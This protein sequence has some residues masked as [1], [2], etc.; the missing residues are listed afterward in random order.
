MTYN[1]A[2]FCLEGFFA[3][4]ETQKC[5]QCDR[6]CFSCVG[7]K[8]NCTS[9]NSKKFLYQSKCVEK[10]P[11]GSLTLQGVN[12]IRLVGASS[13]TEGRVEILHDGL[14]GTVCDDSFDILD[15]QVICR[16]LRLGGA[17]EARTRAKYGQ[18]TGKIWIDDLRCDGTEKRIQDCVMHNGNKKYRYR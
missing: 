18:G 17:L 16:Q 15:A 11:E 2:S 14:W 6:K 9:C 5:L 12:D 10:C 8:E 13:T 7:S 1:C 4:A 3:D